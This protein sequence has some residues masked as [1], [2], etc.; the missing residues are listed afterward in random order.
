MS[1]TDVAD[2]GQVDPATGRKLFR[3][4]WKPLGQDLESDAPKPA[5]RRPDAR[6]RG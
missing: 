3:V 1:L 6:T 4:G 5:A 2:I